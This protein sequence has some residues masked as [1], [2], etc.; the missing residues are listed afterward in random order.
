MFRQETGINFAEYL[1]QYRLDIAKRWLRE[2]NMTVTDIAEKLNYNNPANF[3]RYFRKMEGITPG[4]Y[5]GK[6]EK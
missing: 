5:R 3:I 2:T 4:Q 6:P 1:A